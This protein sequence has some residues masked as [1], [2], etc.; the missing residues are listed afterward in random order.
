MGL[1]MDTKI[2][3]NNKD[4]IIR[5]LG[6]QL[7][8]ALEEIGLLAESYAKYACPVDTGRL[9]SSITHASDVDEGAVFIG[10][11]VEYAPYVEFGARG[12]TPQPFLQVAL[13]H[14]SEYN[15]IIK[16]YLQNG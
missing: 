8:P 9:R 5:E 14:K 12:R 1:S 2:L 6:E 3:Q 7:A 16:N 4:S 10:T 13:D 15:Q 11:N